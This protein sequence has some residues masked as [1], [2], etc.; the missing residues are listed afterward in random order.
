LAIAI[1]AAVFWFKKNKPPPA[2]RYVVATVTTGD[3]FET[4]QS[5]GQVKPVTEV[6]IG[7]QV[8][9]RITKVHVDF[10]SL[11][12][13]GDLLAE[14]DPQLIGAQV[15]ESQARIASAVAN[16]KRSDAN[17]E[18]ARV[19]L[20]RARRVFQEGVGSQQ[21]LDSAQGN[22]DV[23]IA[24]LSSSKAQVSQINATLRSAKT[25]YAFTK[26]YS[27]IDG[28]VI[29]RAVDPGQTVAASFQTPTLFV[30]AQDLRKMRVLADIDEADVGRL[31][32]SMKADIRVDAF[33]GETFEGVVSQ[34]RY[35]PVNQAGV[36]TYAAVI[37][38]ENPDLKLRPGMTA[39][40][41]IHSAEAKGSKRLPNAA[42]R[43]KPTPPKDK[44]GKPIPQDPLPRLAPGKGRIY[45][46]T[47]AKAGDEKIEMREVDIGITDGINTALKSD[48][49][50][51]EVVTD[52]TDEAMRQAGGGRRSF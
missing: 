40:A 29:N 34:V 25:N 35:S 4:I 14:I 2:A 36:V 15:D 11:V 16:V 21:E 28:I 5:T 24:D 33:P 38:V 47:D 46:M 51:L 6:Q 10:N 50:T 52:E 48:L 7:A 49:G 12:K 9:G 43:F 41:T 42:L 18:T 1:A 44:D 20:E 3:V 37:A 45:V 32:E 23:A 19:R 17:L 26:I 8:S 30:I 13:A 31:K 22:Y 27:P 39:T